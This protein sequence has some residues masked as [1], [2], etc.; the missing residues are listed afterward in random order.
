[1]AGNRW[2]AVLGGNETPDA[3]ASGVQVVTAA[4]D[5]EV[6]IGSPAPQPGLSAPADAGRLGVFASSGRGPWW[7][8]AHGGAG[9]DTLAQ[10]LGGDPCRHRWPQPTDTQD[11]PLVVL[12]AR[13]NAHGLDAAARAA[14]DWAAG[15]HPGIDLLGLVVVAAAPGKVPKNLRARTRIVAGGVPRTW[16]VPWIESLHIAGETG[17]LPR[18]CSSVLTNL[19]EAVEEM[20]EQR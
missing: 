17:D 14:R 8:G 18:G 11:R 6:L 13:Q 1:M 5:V 2:A 7:L 19:G 3:S 10:L 4:S 12:V 15:S 9:E 16:M 20:K